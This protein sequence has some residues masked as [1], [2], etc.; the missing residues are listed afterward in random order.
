[1]TITSIGPTGAITSDPYQ[2]CALTI[3]LNTTGVDGTS[4][5]LRDGYNTI[6]LLH[7]YGLKS[8][9]ILKLFYDYDTEEIPNQPEP[10]VAGTDLTE[11]TPVLKYLSGVRYYGTGSTFNLDVVGSDLFDNVYYYTGYVIT[12]DDNNLGAGW[13]IT[14]TGPNQGIIYND[15]SVAGVTDPPRHDEVMTVNNFLVTV[16]TG[17]SFD[18]ARIRTLARDPY[19]DPW[20]T[21]LSPSYDY[22][23]ESHD[24]LST[25]TTEYFYDESWR[26]HTGNHLA[27]NFDSPGARLAFPW[28]SQAYDVAGPGVSNG[29]NHD[30]AI[31]RYG[32]CI[33]STQ[34]FKLKRPDSINQPDYSGAY[35]DATVYLVREFMHDG[36]ASSG[37]TLVT[38][39]TYT[40][41]E[42]KLA[43]PWDGT[44]GGG[45][46]WID[47][48]AVFNFAQW[49]NGN[50]LGGTGSSTGAN[51]YTFGTNN[52]AN[53]GD[54]VY[55][56]VGFTAGQGI[57]STWQIIF[58]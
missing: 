51:H 5:I 54:T 48:T 14:E 11:N 31:F 21:D 53:T 15:A 25:R 28:D 46:V 24:T 4:E 40:S 56:R 34:N 50:P 36:S 26:V 10:T 13:G 12:Y 33:R 22:M 49:N 45:T 55:I 29:V 2:V 3:T 47:M 20:D 38:P 35:M 1:M 57:T 39:G 16:P 6:Q 42:M 44:P 52:I 41:L 17:Y 37:F 9:N 30:D 32:Q 19:A 8:T 43:A 7:S 23:I 18:D 58:D 27:V